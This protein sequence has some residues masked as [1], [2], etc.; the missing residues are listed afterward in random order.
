MRT[1]INIDDQTCQELMYFTDTSSSAKAISN[2]LAEY[3]LLKRKNQLLNLRGQL[4]IADNWQELRG[5]EMQE[6]PRG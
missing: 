1:T 6:N 4:D 2:A 3:I 5:Q